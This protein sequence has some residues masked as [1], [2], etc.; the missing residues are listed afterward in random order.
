[1]HILWSALFLAWENQHKW[2]DTDFLYLAKVSLSD[3]ESWQWCIA[4]LI[5]FLDSSPVSLRLRNK[6]RELIFLKGSFKRATYR[7]SAC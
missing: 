2:R 5:Q 1:M 3:Y 4:I 6:E 7:F